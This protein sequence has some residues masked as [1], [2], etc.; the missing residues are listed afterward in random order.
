MYEKINF[1]GWPNCVR[2]FNKNIE[3]I[4]ATDIG[5]RVLK[6]GFINGQNFF[7]LSNEDS[8]KTGSDQWRIYGGH[9][10]WHAPEA[11]P[12]SYYPDNER[13][14][15]ELSED[16]IVICQK[17]EETTGIIKEIEIELLPDKDDILVKHRLKNENL[18]VVQLAPWAI[19]AMAKGGTAIV[20]QE[21]YGVGDEFLLPARPLVLWHYAQMQDPRWFWGNKF[22]LA[23]MYPTKK[24]EQKIGVLNKQGWAAYSLNNELFIKQFDFNPEAIYPDYNSNNQIYINEKLLEIETLGPL[25]NLKPNETIEH[26]E[27]W[28][29]RNNKVAIGENEIYQTILTFLKNN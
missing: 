28:M 1:N 27:L 29:L 3:V 15:Y 21:P 25:V 18:W 11:I 12:R 17:K 8:G 20:P 10:L 22:I 2:L 26:K 24:E 5:L 23:R 13:I 4:V 14:N 6:A 7:Y 9:R 19:S 16:K